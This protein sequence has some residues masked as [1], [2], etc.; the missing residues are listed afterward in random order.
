MELDKIMISFMVNNISFDE[1]QATRDLINRIIDERAIKDQDY[2]EEIK[3]FDQV[4]EWEMALE[5]AIIIMLTEK[6]SF[7]KENVDEI[8]K[9]AKYM[10]IH[11]ERSLDEGV[12]DRFLEFIS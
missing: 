5:G 9:C 3:N 7:L 6:S 4:G 8:I 12:W 11:N 2:A 1:A 10:N